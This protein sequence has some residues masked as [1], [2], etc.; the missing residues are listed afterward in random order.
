MGT[1]FASPWGTIRGKL[2]DTVGG[3]CHGIDWVREHV[4]PAQ[5][6]TLEL[7]LQLKQG[8]IPPSRFSYKQMNLRR[9]VFQQLGYTGRTNLSTLIYPIWKKL[10]QKRHLPITGI[11]MF[12]KRNAPELWASIP[13]PDKEYNASTNCPDMSKML[14]SEGNLEPISDF[15]SCAYN[16]ATGNVTFNWDTTAIK[17]GKPDDYVFTFIFNKPILDSQWRPNG[18]LYGNAQLLPPVK[19]TDGIAVFSIT[20]GLNPLTLTGYIFCRDK[21][22]EIGY[23]L[24]K[25][26]QVA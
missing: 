11:N 20:P 6:G 12:V 19:R 23:S 8:L 4:S 1:Y 22:G 9:L 17:N 14:V 15:S 25:G 5:R 3:S 2:K 18:Y 21:T 16:S 7:Y 13:N 26:R 10:C 24:S